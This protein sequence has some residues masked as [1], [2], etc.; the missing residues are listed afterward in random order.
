MNNIDLT[1]REFLQALEDAA[2]E[3]AKSCGDNAW[4]RELIQLA[5]AANTLDAFNA[6][7][8]NAGVVGEH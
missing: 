8:E 7:I 6:R 3:L 5:D 1:S 4:K 2:V